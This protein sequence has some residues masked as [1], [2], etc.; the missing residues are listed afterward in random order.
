M[1]ASIVWLI[2]FFAIALAIGFAVMVVGGVLV[3]LASLPALYALPNVRRRVVTTTESVMSREFDSL[4]SPRFLLVYTLGVEVG[5][6][7]LIFTAASVARALPPIYAPDGFSELAPVAAAGI[8]VLAVGLLA[9]DWL[10]GRRVRARAAGE[11]SIFLSVVLFLIVAAFVTVPLL[12]SRLV[13]IL[14]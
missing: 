13:S 9:A 8:V 4:L 10:A 1:D 3:A 7:A 6:M 5:G 2:L 11:W 12:F 14:L